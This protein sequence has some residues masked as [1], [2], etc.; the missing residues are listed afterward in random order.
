MWKKL[1]DFLRCFGRIGLRSHVSYM[2]GICSASLVS[3]M[4]ARFTQDDERVIFLQYPLPMSS[5]AQLGVF[6]IKKSLEF[7]LLDI[8]RIN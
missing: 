8:Q 3:R 1:T 7:E 5:H 4:T 6:E 2:T